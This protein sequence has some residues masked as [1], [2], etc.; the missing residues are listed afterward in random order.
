MSLAEAAKRK[1][2]STS[3][4]RRWIGDGRLRSWRA[5]RCI[6]VDL[7]DVDACMRPPSPPPLGN[8]PA[9]ARELVSRAM[10]GGAQ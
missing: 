3:L 1:G 5:G 7:D 2:V 10:S 6:R 9:R 8:I 4:M